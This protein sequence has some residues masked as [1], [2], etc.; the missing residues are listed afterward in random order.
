MW[1]FNLLVGPWLFF[2]SS[3]NLGVMVIC[4]FSCMKEKLGPS[5]PRIIFSSYSK[6][7]R[8]MPNFF[9]LWNRKLNP[10]CLGF[11]FLVA[12]PADGHLIFFTIR[13]NLGPM[14]FFSWSKFGWWTPSFSYLWEGNP[15]LRD[16]GFFFLV[17]SLDDGHLTFSFVTKKL[18]PWKPDII[19]LIL[20][21]NSGDGHLAFIIHEKETWPLE[22]QDFSFLQQVR[23]WLRDFSH[24]WKRNLGIFIRGRSSVMVAQL[25]SFVKNKLEPRKPKIFFFL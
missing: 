2:S 9:H 5:T 6:F 17:A 8:W 23:E 4:L 14:V 18:A 16:M 12:S 3:I 19:F 13:R 10:Q 21:S 11:F 25:S 15:T 24:L 20:G 1:D 22:A 7:E